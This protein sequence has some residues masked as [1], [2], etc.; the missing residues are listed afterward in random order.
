MITPEQV[1][2]LD[3]LRTDTNKYGY[4]FVVNL[5]K[6]YIIKYNDWRSERNY[7]DM[8]EALWDFHERFRLDLTGVKKVKELSETPPYP[9]KLAEI[10]HLEDPMSPTGYKDVIRA[11]SSF[12]YYKIDGD[13]QIVSAPAKHPALAAWYGFKNMYITRKPFWKLPPELLRKD[14]GEID[15]SCIK[16]DTSLSTHYEGVRFNKT[17]KAY[18]GFFV[19]YGRTYTTGFS[20]TARRAAWKRYN[21]MKFAPCINNASTRARDNATGVSTDIATM[22]SAEYRQIINL[23]RHVVK[24]PDLVVAPPV[25]PLP[26]LDFLKKYKNVNDNTVSKS[27]ENI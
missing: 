23:E 6:S 27:V 21:V 16:F 19:V 12:K 3:Y 8:M 20:D 15:D 7:K 18:E 26:P 10:K 14:F 4:R 5:C 11:S 24:V 13:T 17:R 2:Q 1:E 9:V 25:T 22:Y